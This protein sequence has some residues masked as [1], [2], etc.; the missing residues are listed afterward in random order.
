[1]AQEHAYSGNLWQY[2]NLLISRLK[3]KSAKTTVF[4]IQCYGGRRC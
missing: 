1:M 3:R 2:K 4:R